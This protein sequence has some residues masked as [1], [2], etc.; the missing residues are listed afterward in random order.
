MC[1]NKRQCLRLKS[2]RPSSSTL[3][4]RQTTTYL[5][6]ERIARQL[7]KNVSNA[8]QTTTTTTTNSYFVTFSDAMLTKQMK[9]QNITTVQGEI[10]TQ[11]ET[12]SQ[13]AVSTTFHQ[14]TIKNHNLNGKQ[15][16]VSDTPNVVP[17]IDFCDAD[18]LARRRRLFRIVGVV[19]R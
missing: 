10:E 2:N 11:Y 14:S 3:K 6:S 13:V 7:S 18:A 4:K 5:I 9:C 12:S 16:T 19:N 17:M 15:N 8:N 1:V